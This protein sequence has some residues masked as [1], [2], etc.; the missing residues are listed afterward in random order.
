MVLFMTLGTSSCGI[1]P[2]LTHPHSAKEKKARAC[3]PNEL[4]QLHIYVPGAAVKT[5]YNVHAH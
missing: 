4:L 1:C 2:K 5:M 3:F